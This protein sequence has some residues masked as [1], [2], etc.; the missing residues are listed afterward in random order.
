MFKYITILLT[1]GID[2][3]IIKR[4]KSIFPNGSI[5]MYSSGRR[6]RHGIVDGYITTYAISA[7]QH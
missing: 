2:S 7:Y 5:G 3:Y 4:F 6:G 1:G